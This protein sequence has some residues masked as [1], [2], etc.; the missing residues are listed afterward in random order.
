MQDTSIP[1]PIG[2]RELSKT[3]QIRY[4]QALWDQIA[5]SAE[6]LPVPESHLT[7]AER[8]LADYRRNPADAAPAYDILDRLASRNP[9]QWERR[10]L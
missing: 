5:T 7:L 10:R 1:E 8:R 4:V 6:E 3:D 2:F 9:A